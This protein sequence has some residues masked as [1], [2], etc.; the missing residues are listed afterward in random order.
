[1]RR[2]ITSAGFLALL[3]V[4]HCSAAPVLVTG[5]ERILFVGNNMTGYVPPGAPGGLDVAVRSVL[6][7][8][9]IDVNTESFAW[10]GTGDLSEIYKEGLATD[11][12]RNGG[13]DLVVLQG[14]LEPENV[15]LGSRDSLFKTVKLFDEVITASGGKTMLFMTY[16]NVFFAS[17]PNVSNYVAIM[18]ATAQNYDSASNLIG[19]A[20]IA[21]VG[22]VFRSFVE[23]PPPGKDAWLLFEPNVWSA[24]RPEPHGQLPNQYGVLVT[25]YVFY[26]VLTG[27][28]SPIGLKQTYYPGADSVID[29][30][31]QSRTNIITGRTMP[32]DGPSG[33]LRQAGAPVCRAAE[34]PALA[35]SSFLLDGTKCRPGAGAPGGRTVRVLIGSDGRPAAQAQFTGAGSGRQ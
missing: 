32:A 17:R 16:P 24:G 1:M 13:Y 11:K 35:P 21:P 14:W 4:S 12:I 25:A 10:P 23:S 26:K 33:V 5:G 7:S 19:N 27:G 28:R 18:T 20:P 2:L 8:A 29:K 3:G 22:L 6:A 34:A 31:L 9:S 30:E 15:P